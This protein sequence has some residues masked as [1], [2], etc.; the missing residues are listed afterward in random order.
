M[1]CAADLAGQS[2]WTMGLGRWV[3]QGCVSASSCAKKI[4][5]WLRWSPHIV[6]SGCRLAQTVG[7]PGWPKIRQRWS[8][9]SCTQRTPAGLPCGIPGMALEIDGAVQHAP[10][11]G[12]QSMRA[13]RTIAASACAIRAEGHFCSKFAKSCAGLKHTSERRQVFHVKQG[14]HVKPHKLPTSVLRPAKWENRRC[15]FDH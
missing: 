10:Q 11:P 3:I 4:I 13:I 12:R 1:R 7:R 5:A 8:A 6:G 9:P 2:G 14:G 15:F